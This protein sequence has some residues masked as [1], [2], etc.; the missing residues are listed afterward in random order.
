LLRDGAITV[1][2]TPAQDGD[3]YVELLRV[4][5][6]EFQEHALKARLTPLAQKWKRAVRFD[7]V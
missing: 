6:I 1:T 4:V 2:F 3:M 7:A 5:A